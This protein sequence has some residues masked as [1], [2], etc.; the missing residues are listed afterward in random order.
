MPDSRGQLTYFTAD[1]LSA[2]IWMRSSLTVPLVPRDLREHD[3]TC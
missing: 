1:R 2:G 3:E